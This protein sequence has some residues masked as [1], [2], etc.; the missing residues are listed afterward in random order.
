MSLR[1]CFDEFHKMVDKECQKKTGLTLEDVPTVFCIDYW[2]GDYTGDISV[3]DAKI[4]MEACI[5]DI[6]K[7]LPV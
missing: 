4:A 3:H 1:I 5:E 6:F 7:S 2:P